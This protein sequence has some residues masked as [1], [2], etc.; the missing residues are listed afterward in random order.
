M[1]I[2]YACELSSTNVCMYISGAANLKT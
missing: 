2:M 1:Y